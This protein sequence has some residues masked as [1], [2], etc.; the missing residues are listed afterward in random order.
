MAVLAEDGGSPT[1]SPE[2]PD[3]SPG[4][5]VTISGTGFDPGVSYD[6]PVIRPDGFIIVGDGGGELGWDTV[7]ADD[8]GEFTYSYQLDGI[9]GLYTVEVYPSPWDGVRGVPL[10]SATFTDAINKSLEQCENGPLS[11]I[12]DPCVWRQGNLGSSNSHYVEGKSVPYRATLEKVPQGSSHFIRITYHFTAGGIKAFDFL[13]RFNRSESPDPCA[14]LSYCPA[15]SGTINIPSDSFPVPPPVSTYELAQAERTFTIRGGTLTSVSAI[16]HSGPVGGNSLATMNVYFTADASCP[17]AEC[18]VLILWGGHLARAFDWGAGQGAASIPGGSYHMSYQ[19]DGSGGSPDRGIQA[20]SLPPE[21]TIRVCKHVIPNDASVWGFTLTG[22][23]SGNTSGLGDNQCS[24]FPS[25]IPGS[26]TLSETTQAGYSTS[27]SCDNGA[28]GTNSVSFNLSALQ[29]VICTFINSPSCIP[30]GPDNDCDGVDDD[31]DGP[32]DEHYVPT[33]TSCGVGECADTGTLSCVGGVEVDSCEE[34]TPGPELCNGLDDDCDGSLED[35][36]VDEGWYG[37]QTSCG[38]GECA[39]TGELTCQGGL[40][41][42][43]CEEGTPGDEVC[44][45]LDNDCDNLVDED[46]VCEADVMITG[47]SFVDPPPEIDVGVPTLVT[48]NKVIHHY[49]PYPGPVEVTVTKTATAPE[50]CSI[51]PDNV[52]HQ[53]VLY[54][55]VDLVLDEEFFIECSKASEHTF[56]I[57]N[58]VSEPKDAL[59]VDPNMANNSASTDLTVAVTAEADL[60]QTVPVPEIPEA[61]V[62]E[63]ATLHLT[64]TIKNNG[65]YGPVEAHNELTFWFP[66]DGEQG[67]CEVRL[68]FPE[69]QYLTDPL[70][71]GQTV[72]APLHSLD[73]DD[74][75]LVVAVDVIAHCHASGLFPWAGSAQLVVDSAHVVDPHPDNNGPPPEDPIEVDVPFIDEADLK[76]LAVGPDWASL[77]PARLGIDN[78]GDTKV[79]EDWLDGVDN[80]GDTKVDEDLPDFKVSQ[81]YSVNLVDLIHNN[82]PASPV[83]VTLQIWGMVPTGVQF[84]YHCDGGERVEVDTTVTDPCL[85]GTTVWANPGQTF[86]VTLAV[87]PIAAGVPVPPVART[88]DWHCL[89]PSQHVWILNKEIWPSDE[90]THDPN[91][92]NNVG[93]V[94]V[95]INCIAYADAKITA[96]WIEGCDDLDADTV[97][98]F[99]ETTYPAPSEIPVNQ[100][101]PILVKKTIHNNGPYGPVNL[102]TVKTATASPDCTVTPATHTEDI[103]NVG[104]GVDVTHTEQFKV[105][106]NKP[107]QHTFTFD[108][109]ISVKTPHVI[110]PTPGNNTAHTAW[111]VDAIAQADLQVVAQRTV[112]WPGPAGIKVSENKLVTLET[113]VRNNGLYGSVEALFEGWLVAPT[114]CTAVPALVS[115]QVILAAGETKTIQQQFTI[116]CAEKCLRNFVFNNRITAKDPHVLDLPTENNTKYSNLSLDTWAQADVIIVSQGFVTPPAEMQISVNTPVTLRKV[117]RNTGPY[118]GPVTVTITKTATAPAG[119]TIVPLSDSEDVLLPDNLDKIV[120]ETFTIHCLG[121]GTYTF[122]VDNVVGAPHE[123]HVADPN[124]PNTAHTDLIV[125]AIG[126]ADVKIVSQGFVDPPAEIDVSASVPV[127]LRKVLRNDGP[128]TGDVTVTITE[129]ATAPA[130]CTIDPPTYSQQVLLPDNTNVT[131]DEVFTIHCSKPSEHTFSVANV[132]SGPKDPIIIDPDMDNNVESTDLTVDAVAKVDVA[133]SQTILGWPTDINVGEDV[134]V[135]VE[136]TLTASVQP[137]ATTIEVPSVNVTVTKTA[138]APAGCSVVA[139]IAVQKVVLTTTPLVYNETFTIRC[140]QPSTHGPFTFDNAVSG[141]TDAHVS[142]PNM[143]NN[144]AHT[145]GLSVNALAKV[146]VAVSQT[147]VSP[148]TEIDVGDDVEVTVQKTITATVQAPATTA[149]IPLV[150]VTVT[151]TASAPAGCTVVAPIAV[152]KVVLTTGPLV[153]NET[154]T[155]RCSEPSTHGPFIFNDTVS[156]PK[157]AHISDPNAGNNTAS[158]SL[159]VDAIGHADMKV[160]AQYVEDPPAEIAPSEN[161]P[162]VLKK[163]IH[164][165]GPWG[166]VEAFTETHVAVPADCTATPNPHIQQFYNVPVSVD[167]VHNEPFTIH[168]SKLGIYTFTFDDTVGLKEPHVHDPVSGNNSWSTPLTLNSVAKADVKI[169][170]ASFVDPPTK[171][172]YDTPLDIT[173]QKVIHNNG[174]WAPVDIAIT[175]TATAPLGCTVVPKSVPS[176]ISAVPVSIDQVVN[177]V[178]TI[179]CTSIG[180]KTFGFDNSIAVATPFVSDSNLANNSSHKLLSVEDDL[181]SGADSDSDGVLNGVDNCALSY[182]PGQTD[183]DIDGVGD[184]CDTGDSDADVFSDAVEVYVGTDPADNCPDVVGADDAWPLDNDITK[185]I[186]VTGDV[187]AYVGG[188]GA[189]PGDLNWRQ[190]LDL[191]KSGDITVTGD[192]FAYVG[193][194][195]A[196]CM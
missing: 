128:Y 59:I 70:D 137:P 130:D 99:G 25:R 89:E 159:T 81:D 151:K 67:G 46:H 82:G 147:I 108:N 112:V 62:S 145:T 17:G 156:G 84:S 49:G 117:L 95:G 54:E 51:S 34:G 134:V 136:K 132:V 57:D 113:D 109:V 178:W 90:Y 172:P 40:Q 124:L 183:A 190:R 100:D 93:V 106:C 170:G 162:I 180:L 176:S 52:S 181:D 139:P 33:A 64:A 131:V 169:T 175:A 27:V 48:L 3:Y 114:P 97:C 86:R 71:S 179:R 165:N 189:G 79:D 166:P 78:D 174:P 21:G 83:G 107:S 11:L 76:D 42:D 129:T 111:T 126:K 120:D 47:Q 155:I 13:T 141:P 102:Q 161:V 53:V 123:V 44:D 56:T 55:S 6:I 75:P 194:I 143:G 101:V 69:T 149:G 171:L 164:N 66:E 127:K 148:P 15:S 122:S 94:P 144:T 7:T 30:T 23:S 157:D 154:F 18:T 91:P 38:V 160:V 173:L 61:K 196:S 153:Y 87:P 9:E 63:D 133:V 110:D 96:Q 152:Q 14:D 68:F 146:D 92:A 72:D 142:D 125:K 5:A 187:F 168:C 28:S 150:N 20:G 2:K 135:T 73:V 10:A 116:H 192:V 29:T 58:D 35:D 158:S 43:T 88:F 8:G 32:V 191:D 185:D 26:Y 60:E 19:V 184:A 16:T 140:S 45:G 177:E 195:G 186:T 85:A 22:P 24:D 121:D 1:V 119:C 4:E 167:I 12:V 193:K 188:I 80:D 31:C 37:E 182:N 103:L 98:D 65:P 163:V 104:V 39:D 77:S 74:P 105:R 41:V 138:S 115:Q 50:D 36:G 118:S